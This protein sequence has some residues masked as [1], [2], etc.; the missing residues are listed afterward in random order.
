AAWTDG[1]AN[2]VGA[3]GEPERVIQYLVSANFFD[4]LGVRMPLGR[5]F[6]PGDDEPGRERE[7]VLSDALWRNR[8][9]GDP[10]IVGKTIRLDDQDFLVTGVAPPKFDFPRAAQL[11]TPFAP[12][13]AARNSRRGSE[14]LAAGRLRPGRT[15]A[16]LSAELE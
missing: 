11:W 5:G 7:V 9:G 8:F 14:W 4:V 16:Q 10:A 12:T 2:I 15:L 1:M 13:P 3:S 6:A